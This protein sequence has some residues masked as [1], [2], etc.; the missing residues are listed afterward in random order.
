MATEND[1][2]RDQLLGS[3]PI[4]SDVAQHRERVAKGIE[5]GRKRIR[6][7]GIVVTAVWICCV[8][9]V[10]VHLWFDADSAQLPRGPFLACVVFAW[11]GIELIK[12]HI[13]RCRIDLLK[14]IKQ[15]QLQVFELE[16]SIGAR[17][18]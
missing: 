4:P 12:H 14:E 17:S 18:Q 3:V 7:E 8:V 2:I 10:T 1:P 15:L 11:G 13:N 16:R 9:W 5:K 6:I